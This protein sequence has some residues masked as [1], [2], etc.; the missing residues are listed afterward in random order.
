[1]KWQRR[2]MQ[3]RQSPAEELLSGLL[4]TGTNLLINIADLS[5]H[6]QNEVISQHLNQQQGVR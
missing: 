1:M 4:V 6:Y 5:L 3:L 2:I